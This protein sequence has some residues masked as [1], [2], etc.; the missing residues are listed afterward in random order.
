MVKGV[1][2]CAAAAGREQ[3]TRSHHSAVVPAVVPVVRLRALARTGPVQLLALILVL[4]LRSCLGL[5]LALVTV[6][7]SAASRATI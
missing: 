7:P 4:A 6:H 2:P 1:C 3:S 5:V